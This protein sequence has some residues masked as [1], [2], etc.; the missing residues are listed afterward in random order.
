MFG[1]LASAT[2]AERF[3]QDLQR[4]LAVQLGIGSLIDLSHPAFTQLGDDF[5]VAE[6]CADVECHSF[7]HLYLALSPSSSSTIT[8][9]L[10]AT[11]VGLGAS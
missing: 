8:W 3:R 11:A 10:R 4:H 9:T 6:S 1:I 2:S 5:V 7:R